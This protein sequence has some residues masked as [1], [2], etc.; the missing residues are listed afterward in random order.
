MNLA[1]FSAFMTII[2]GTLSTFRRRLHRSTIKNCGGWLFFFAFRQAEQRT[3]IMDDRFKHLGC[4]PT[5][6]LLVDRLPR[7]QIVWHRTPRT[8]GTDYVAHAV[9]D[10]P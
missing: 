7:R 5:L 1:A 2:P 4:N 8:T 10:F 9:E 6:R 3:Q